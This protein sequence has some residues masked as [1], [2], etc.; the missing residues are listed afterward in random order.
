MSSP[1]ATFGVFQALLS[2]SVDLDP[3]LDSATKA[4]IKTRVAYLAREQEIVLTE[5]GGFSFQGNCVDDIANRAIKVIL[6]APSTP[7]R[8]EFDPMIFSV[9]LR[10]E[11]NGGVRGFMPGASGASALPQVVTADITLQYRLAAADPWSNWDRNSL[12]PEVTWIQFAAN[13]EDQLADSA[14]PDLHVH[15]E[16]I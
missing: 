1:V 15:A 3:N 8:V 10:I 13:I 12:L 16:Q 4:S 11:G 9:P 2:R 5:A 6:G 7:N 14:L